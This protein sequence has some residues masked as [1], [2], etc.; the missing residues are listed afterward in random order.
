[1]GFTCFLLADKTELDRMFT[2]PV[3]TKVAYHICSES[4]WHTASAQ[5]CQHGLDKSVTIVE[6]AA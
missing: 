4:A 1:M 2:W 6:A 5:L 3:D